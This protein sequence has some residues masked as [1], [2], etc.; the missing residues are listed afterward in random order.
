MGT[1]VAVQAVRLGRSAAA[2]AKSAEYSGILERISQGSGTQRASLAEMRWDAVLPFGLCLSMLAACA[3]RQDTAGDASTTGTGVLTSGEQQLEPADAGVTAE[4]ALS[5]PSP[6]P[7]SQP[8][9]AAAPDAARPQWVPRDPSF[10]IIGAGD[11]DK[12]LGLAPLPPPPAEIAIDAGGCEVGIEIR[13][14]P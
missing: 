4:P 12:N 7:Q 6:S 5:G 1:A 8:P 2:R 13:T 11:R 14:R 10:S 3:R 9:Q